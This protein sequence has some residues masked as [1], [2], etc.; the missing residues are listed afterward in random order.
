MP[1][2]GRAL[3]AILA[4]SACASPPEP[5]KVAVT[6]S[7]AELLNPQTCGS[8]HAEAYAQW[9]GSMH[10]YAAEDPVFV[11]L[12][13]RGQRETGGTL[14]TFCV[15]CHAPMAVVEKATTD[16]KNLADLPASLRGVTCY[17]CHNVDQVTGTHNNPLQLRND[18]T[19][20]GGLRDPVPQPGHASA[21]S[22]H[23][24]RS[25]TNSSAMCGSCHDIVN[26]HG[27]AI[28]RT[29]A[30]FYD[31]ALSS[32]ASGNTCA[33]CHMD[34][35]GAP[36]PLAD[37]PNLPPRPRLNHS[38][39]G[40]DVVLT[41]FADQQNQRL[42]VQ[43]L[44][45]S[46]LQAA[47]CVRPSGSGLAVRVIL[48]NVAAGH[49]FP[50]GAAHDRRLWT[51]VIAEAGGQIL[52]QT[53]QRAADASPL[54][55]N[56]VDLWLLRECLFDDQG[57]SV[58][59]LWEATSY[60]TNT[61][62]ALATF[63]ARDPRFYQTHVLQKCPRTPNPTLSLPDR[64]SLRLR[65]QPIGLDVLD[66]LIGSGDLDPAVRDKMPTFNVGAPLVWSAAAATSTYVENGVVYSCV[67]SAHFNTSAAT[68]LAPQNAG[69][70]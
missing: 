42:A 17:Y 13:A 12:N 1:V 6:Y 23:L 50:S 7:R 55:A 20:V 37:L 35:A 40:V 44:L 47:L 59:M 58:D 67:S 2:L 70:Q 15:N 62:P 48:D 38:F 43:S 4:L 28:E 26:G 25:H 60:A 61:L 27:V 53:G 33:Q 34:Q 49:S 30:E 31:S 52:Y 18:V 36:G 9:A 41:D 51:E 22:P 68:V 45:D 16:G 24:D 56:D 69:C 39:A 8:C 64:V 11:A 21:Y 14:G 5:A 32:V 63:D 57:R 46:S 66:V 54:D 3:L 29:F 10:A 65:L 19:M